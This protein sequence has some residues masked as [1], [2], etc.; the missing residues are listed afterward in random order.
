MT[1]PSAARVETLLHQSDQAAWWT[2][3]LVLGLRGDGDP[4]LARAA[5]DVLAALDVDVVRA[6]QELDPAASAA[7]AAAPLLQA[8]AV[9]RGEADLWAH[10]PDEALLAQGR[11]SAQLVPR[12]LQAAL[13]Q[14]DG[15]APALARPGAR[16]LDVGTGVGALAAAYAEALPAVSVVGI[17][18]LPRVLALAEEVVAASPAAER[19]ELREQDVAML[20]EDEV[21]DLAWIPAPFVPER[22]FGAGLAAMVRALKP[23]GWLVVGHG[24]FRGEP[25]DDAI[26]RLK[27]VAFGGTAL[28]D[29]RAAR[30]LTDAG[31][32]AVFNA[33]TP[34]GAP[35]VTLGR[36]PS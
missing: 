33:P 25:L 32:T 26:T 23:G 13:P 1:E 18:V 24:R 12:F 14:L 21:Y 16:I 6:R 8:A 7:Q 27:T 22:A 30:L 4:D 11:A 2:V 17:D 36:K 19:V 29:A 10:Q 28:D 3:A 9:L 31:L 34:P 20:D 5:E 35:A 15:L